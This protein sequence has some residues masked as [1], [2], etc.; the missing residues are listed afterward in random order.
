MSRHGGDGWQLDLMLLEVIS[1]LND[2]DSVSKHSAD[3]WWLGLTI[4]EAISNPNESLTL[5]VD[6][7]GM[8]WPLDLTILDISSGLHDLR[9]HFQP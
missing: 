9:G 5:R 2:S 6:M 3:G 8:G 1:T 4:L 7:V